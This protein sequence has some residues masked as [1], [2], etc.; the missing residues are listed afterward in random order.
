ML[1]GEGMDSKQTAANSIPPEI[2]QRLHAW[3]WLFKLANRAHYIVGIV[4]VASSALAASAIFYPVWCSVTSAIC[5]ATLGFAQPQR[6]YLKFVRAWRILDIAALRYRY[7]N[8]NQ[9][10]L[11][12]A[13]VQAEAAI[14][15]S[16]SEN[17][18]N[19]PNSLGRTV[20]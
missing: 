10:E 9:A 15:E 12:A 13:L 6:V 17:P 16:E 18:P 3:L 11:F 1:Q 19:D 20:K 7:G 14:S 5:L 4:G 8:L 2:L